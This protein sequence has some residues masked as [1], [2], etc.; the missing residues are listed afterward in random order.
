MKALT[1]YIEKG[2][3]FYITQCIEHSNCFAQGKTIEETISTI[4]EV[5]KLIQA[6][7]RPKLKVILKD[8]LVEAF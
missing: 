2:E 7:K 4:K 5:I 1:I 6:V 3:K 8:K